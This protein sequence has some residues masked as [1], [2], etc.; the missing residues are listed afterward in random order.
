MT[1]P[2]F[3]GIKDYPLPNDGPSVTIE[4]ATPHLYRQYGYY[5]PY[6][7]A[8]EKIPEAAMVLQML[9]LI[10]KDFISYYSL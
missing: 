5:A 8:K 1:L 10:E 3:T 2:H 4:V 6:T 7:A 9:Q